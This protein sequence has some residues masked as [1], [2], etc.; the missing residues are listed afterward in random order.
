[1][2]D[3]KYWLKRALHRLAK[4]R[5]I[6]SVR[7]CLE[8]SHHVQR[9]HHGHAIIAF[10]WRYRKPDKRNYPLKQILPRRVRRLP[11]SFDLRKENLTAP[12]GNQGNE[13][14]CTG[15]AYYAMKGHEKVSGTYP[16]HG[17]SPRHIYNAAR[18]AED[19]LSEEGA[20]SEDLFKYG[21]K[22][23]VCRWDTWPYHA[24]VDSTRWPPPDTAVQEAPDYK[25]QSYAQLNQAG[26]DVIENIKQTLHQVKSPV[27]MGTAWPKSWVS[28]PR[29]VCPL[30]SDGEDIVGGHAWVIVGWD[31]RE[32]HLIAENSWGAFWGDR[33]FFAFPYEAFGWFAKYGY[34]CF[35]GMDAPSPKPPGPDPDPLIRFLRELIEWL[36]KKLKELESRK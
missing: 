9:N 23:G 27:Y 1:M 8:R 22:V 20:Y 19:R 35:K 36:Q 32:Q 14:S 7:Y 15:F 29:G 31:D 12:V 30:P 28:P 16:E 5:F 6:P 26:E 17:I 11:S 24:H 34:D 2:F 21:L 3:W 4:K 25:I 33:G 10:G 18:A 13:G